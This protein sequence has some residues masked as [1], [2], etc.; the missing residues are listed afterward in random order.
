MT[1]GE[2]VVRAL[3]EHGVDLVFGI[4][5]THTLELH[6]HLAACGIRH[7]TPRHE[8][9][10]AYAADGYAR[11]STRPGVVLATSGP[12]VINTATAAATAYADSVPMLIVSPAMPTDVEGRDTG[13]LHE[14]KDQRGAMDALVAWSRNARTPLEAAQAIHDAFAHFASGRPRPVHVEI[15]L[16]V[17]A[18]AGDEVGAAAAGSNG[19]T[20]DL[21]AAA[22]LLAAAERPVV[23]AGGGARGADVAALGAPVI[24]TV[25]GK[26]VLDERHPLSLGASIRLRAAQRFLSD[27]D[28]VVA[29]GTE[30]GESDLWGPVPELRGKV[31][32]IDVDPAQRDKNV[33]ADVALIGDARELVTGLAA[34]LPERAPEDLEAVREAI[35]AEALEDGA[36]WLPLMGALDEALGENGILAGDSTQASYYGAVH[37]LPM[38]ARRRFIY[39]TGYATLGYALPAAIGA[40]LAAPERPVIALIGDGGLLFTVSELA[41]AAELGLPLPVVVPNNG[42]YGEIR[43]QMVEAGIN[44]VGVDLRVPDLP[45]LGEAF[46]GAGLRVEHPGAL[47]PVLREALERPGPTLIEVPAT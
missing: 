40:K 10:G 5:G 27:R 34:A 32:R 29:I 17:L 39:P 41:T 45:K 14:G 44:P 16:D 42:G 2:A 21:T 7:V 12:G 9:G 19:A 38:D 33:P 23:V 22:R 1:G 6:R 3:A 4:P 11:V 37:L 25:N 46:G 47:G 20:P 43:D 26:G 8:A 24:T 30:L 36:P 28:V 31:I 15:P 13:F 18:T 35:R